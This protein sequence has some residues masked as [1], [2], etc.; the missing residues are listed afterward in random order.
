MSE[1]AGMSE[2]QFESEAARPRA[3]EPTEDYAARTAAYQERGSVGVGFGRGLAG[4]LLILNG[5]Y[6]F[7]IGLAAV[8]RGGFFAFHGAYA[9]HWSISS[10]GWLQLAL[11]VVIF[12]AGVS[13]LLGMLWARILGAVLAGFSTI[14]NFMFLPYYPVW[15]TI[16][17]AVDIFIIWAL[18]SG[19]RRSL[20]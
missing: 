9:Y 4:F 11:G 17:I 14:A 1:T 13:I 6:G 15:A 16:V 19:G 20:A 3:A 12:A 18:L 8:I 5:L 7:L 2:T 10:W